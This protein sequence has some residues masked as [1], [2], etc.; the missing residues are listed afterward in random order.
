M[1]GSTGAEP[2]QSFWA[3]SLDRA[4]PTLRI[5]VVLEFVVISTVYIG[6]ALFVGFGTDA[7]IYYRATQ[8]WLGGADPW[9]ASYQGVKFAAPPPTLL[10]MAPMSLLPENVAVPLTVALA[11]LA[12]VFALRHLRL[13]AY[14]LLFPP[15]VEG[16][17]VGNPDIIVLAVLLT[18]VSFLAP[19]AKIYAAV[20]L[21]S[22][23][24]GHP[25]LPQS[26]PAW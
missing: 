12:A 9:G 11:V 22:W 20:P 19:L 6:I 3:R 2:A 14:W 8:A 26:C 23:A 10:F 5:A 24:D 4:E 15:L 25:W 17:T 18:P 7:H 13:P 21:A 1:A 16:V